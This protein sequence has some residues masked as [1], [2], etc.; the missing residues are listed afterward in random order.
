MENSDIFLLYFDIM[1]A[2]H[3]LDIYGAHKSN[4]APPWRWDTNAQPWDEFNLWLVLQGNSCG[5]DQ[6]KLLEDNPFRI[7]DPT[8][9]FTLLRAC[10]DLLWIGSELGLDT[11]EIP[12][13]IATLEGG[14]ETLWNSEL[15]SYDAR[16]ARKGGFAGCIS[17][18]SVLCWYAG[19]PADSMLTHYRRIMGK[20]PHGFPSHDPDS[21]L[22]EPKRYWRG[23]IWAMMNMMIGEG[24]SEAGLTEG[25]EL[26]NATADLILKSGFAE[27]FDPTDGS[28]AGGVL[29]TWTAAV[30]LGWASPSARRG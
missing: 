19:T 30:W 10:R 20:V 24:L 26:R 29:F 4:C 6:A 15:G 12:G 7:A 9:T 27:Y 22:F 16:D 17:N 18:A 14:A 21:P 28:A 11:S 1:V 23:P 5:W 3:S 13:W 25:E 8:M 2:Y